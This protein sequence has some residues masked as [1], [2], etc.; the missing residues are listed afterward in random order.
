MS[1][2]FKV[3]FL[4]IHVLAWFSIYTVNVIL[5]LAFKNLINNL[6]TNISGFNKNGQ[7]VVTYSIVEMYVA[8]YIMSCCQSRFINELF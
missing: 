1:I 2:T 7:I 4:D 8:Q 3:C 5:I 6:Q